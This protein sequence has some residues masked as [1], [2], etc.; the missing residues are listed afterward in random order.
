MRKKVSGLVMMMVL[1][2]FV[3]MGCGTKEPASVVAPETE[4]VTEVVKAE[5]PEEPIQPMEVVVTHELGEVMI[6]EVPQRVIVFDY[7]TIDSL[8][9]MGVEILGLPKSNV[10]AYLDAFNDERY[11]NVGT[12]FEPDFEKIFELAPDLILISGRQAAVYEELAKIAPTIYLTVDTQDYLGSFEH[13]VSTLGQIFGKEEEASKAVA[14]VSERVKKVKDLATASG[15]EALIVM[16][17][18]GAL[19]VYGPNSRFNVI[20]DDFGFAAADPNIEVSNHGQSISFEYIVDVNPA[21]IFVIDRAAVTGGSEAAEK[22][23]DNDL[24]AMTDA[25]QN[26]EI[27]YLNAHVW[28]VASGGIQS[29]NI[30]IDEVLKALL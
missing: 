26:N 24:V 18:D 12:L 19:S 20:H 21:L 6:T 10:P 4:P 14:E 28:Y 22:V 8:N 16:A 13:N 1:S 3:L 23:L 5:A 25:Y 27:H 30:M 7:A 11:E 15:K 9:Q 29:T 2:V 17:N